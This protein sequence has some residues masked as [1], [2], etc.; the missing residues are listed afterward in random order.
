M[1]HIRNKLLDPRIGVLFE[2]G[3]EIGPHTVFF[4]KRVYDSIQHGL[5]VIGFVT[6]ENIRHASIFIDDIGFA[7]LTYIAEF[8]DTPACSRY[9]ARFLL[10]GCHNYQPLFSF[11]FKR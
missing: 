11:Q 5:P 4:A 1:I 8:M 6:D 3:I 2:L 10:L 7:V 9:S